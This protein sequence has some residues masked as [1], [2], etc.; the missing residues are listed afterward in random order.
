MPQHERV[1]SAKRHNGRW[2]DFEKRLPAQTKTSVGISQ[3]GQARRETFIAGS[4]GQF[5]QYGLK[6]THRLK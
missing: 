6:K 4:H 2:E 1:K 5:F 3:G